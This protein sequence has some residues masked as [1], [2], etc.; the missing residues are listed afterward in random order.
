ME[1]KKVQSVG[2]TVADIIGD[3]S[4]EGIVTVKENGTAEQVQGGKVILSGNTE[5]T[6]TSWGA[7][8]LNVESSRSDALV[9]Y[10]AAIK[11]YLANVRAATYEASVVIA[12]S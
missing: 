11:Q 6:F 8:H 7:S 9:D 12:N 2:V 1:I 10:I 5:A 4:I 3:Y